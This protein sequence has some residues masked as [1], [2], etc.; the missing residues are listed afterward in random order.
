[1]RWSKE[2]V[3]DCVIALSSAANVV[4]QSEKGKGDSYFSGFLSK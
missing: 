2:D 1:M 3:Q 4:H